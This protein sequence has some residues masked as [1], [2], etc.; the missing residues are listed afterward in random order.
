MPSRED[1]IQGLKTRLDEWNSAIDE[2]ELKLHKVEA[3][4]KA[5]LEEQLQDLKKKRDSARND[6]HNVQA[7][8]AE[9]LEDMKSGLD[10]AWQSMNDSFRSALSRFR[11]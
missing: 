4:S 10:L 3:D 8:S 1:F 5:K 7:A 11:D 6:L 9:A 2:L